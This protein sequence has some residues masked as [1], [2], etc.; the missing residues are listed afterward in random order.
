MKTLITLKFVALY[1][2]MEE[3]SE[4]LHDYG[5][6]SKDSIEI[7]KPHIIKKRYKSCPIIEKSTFMI[8][9]NDMRSMYVL[10]SINSKKES[11]M[12][13]GTKS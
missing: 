3:H 8:I 1:T 11:E 7:Q 4:H 13:V 6:L 9:E 12:I 5:S 10:I 2:R